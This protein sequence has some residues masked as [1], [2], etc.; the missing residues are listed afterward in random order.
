MN[1]I[2]YKAS[3]QNYNKEYIQNII[4]TTKDPNIRDQKG[5]SLLK[6]ACE[7]VGPEYVRLLIEKGADINALDIFGSTCL[8]YE[9]Y[10]HIKNIECAKV[11]LEYGADVNIVNNNQLTAFYIASES[12]KIDLMRLLL[13][14]SADVNFV[15]YGST[16]LTSQMSR[17]PINRECIE[18]LIDYGANIS[19]VDIFGRTSLNIFDSIYKEVDNKGIRQLLTNRIQQYVLK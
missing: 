7:Y 5:N 10:S 3:L 16:A 15:H 4:D 2:N 14:Y 18:L 11:L 8:I 9:C 19:F 13:E 6:L 17:S 1:Y 12:K